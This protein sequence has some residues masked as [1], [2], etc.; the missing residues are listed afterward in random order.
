MDEQHV[1][2]RQF[3]GERAYPRSLLRILRQRELAS[4]AG[5]SWI[6]ARKP[7]PDELKHR[8]LDSLGPSKYY[9]GTSGDVTCLAWSPNGENFAAGS[10]AITDERSMQYNRPNNLL[11]GRHERDVLH[12]L[13][14]HHVQ[15]PE[16]TDSGNTNALRSM[17]ES[18]DPAC[19]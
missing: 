14:E 12:E 13:P 17:K 9:K 11:L 3:T 19:S 5:R 18:Q 15:R 16:V 10:I 8:A 1:Y 6:S 2:R 4:S 7:V